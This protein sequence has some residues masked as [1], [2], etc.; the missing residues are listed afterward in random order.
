MDLFILETF[1]DVD[2]IGAAIARGAL[3]H[4][5]AH[6]RA[7]DDRGGRQQP[8]RHAARKSSARRSTR[9]APTSSGST[10]VSGPRRCSRRSSGWRAPRRERCRPSP[11]PAGP[12]TSR[13]ARSTLL[14]RIHGA[15]RAAFHPARRTPRRWLLRHHARTHPA[16][17]PRGERAGARRDARGL[18]GASRRQSN[19]RRRQSR[20]TDKSALARA[21]AQGRSVVTVEL[22]PPKGVRRQPTCWPR[23][24]VWPR[25]ASTPSRCQKAP[26]AAPG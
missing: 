3:A 9:G 6:R 12:A 24:G 10:A 11:T 15:V 5:P 22:E 1:R 26:R 2:E 7:D 21:L 17:P 13:A 25:S 19:P 8:G 20:A 16:D 4:R 23:P 14:A 18:S